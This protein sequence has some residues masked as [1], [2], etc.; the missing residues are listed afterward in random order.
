MLTPLLVFL[1][2]EQAVLIFLPL[3]LLLSW[4]RRALAQVVLSL[5]P[6]LIQMALEKA[7]LILLPRAT[8]PTLP[9]PPKNLRRR[10]GGSPWAVGSRC[11]WRPSGHLRRTRRRPRT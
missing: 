2:L 10:S 11:G 9:V 4:R 7:P 1:F 5:L 8:L 3:L 6:L